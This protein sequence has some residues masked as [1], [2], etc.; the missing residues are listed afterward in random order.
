MPRYLP[1]IM[2]LQTPI[3]LSESSPAWEAI[4]MPWG[5]RWQAGRGNRIWVKA[6]V[7]GGVSV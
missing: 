3:H 2:V 4:C 7:K 6:W 5:R 1:Y